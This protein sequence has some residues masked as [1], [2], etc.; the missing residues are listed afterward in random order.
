MFWSFAHFLA[1]VAGPCVMIGNV[2][3][4]S[5]FEQVPPAT[6]LA[7][8]WMSWRERMLLKG[9]KRSEHFVAW[10]TLQVVVFKLMCVEVSSNCEAFSAF[11]AVVWMYSINMGGSRSGSSENSL[12]ELTR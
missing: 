5:G 10:Q 3:L 4:Q 8:E 2:S 9:L 1:Q 11:V 7:L 6:F 12:A